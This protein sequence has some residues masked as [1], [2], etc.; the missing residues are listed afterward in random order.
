MRIPNVG[1][2][3]MNLA[4]VRLRRLQR[5]SRTVI[6]AVQRAGRKA[7]R[8]GE[9][10]PQVPALVRVRVQRGQAAIERVG[11]RAR[12]FDDHVLTPYR[13]ER[14][15]K[16]TLTRA[17]SGQHPIIV[18]PWTSEVGYEVLYWLPFL[19]WA[20][21]HYAVR[22]ERLVAVSRG[23]TAAWYE[24]IAR[25]YVEIFDLIEPAALAAHAA[26]RPAGGDQ[27]QMAP[28]EF[29]RHLT[30][31]V[32]QR[33]GVN[34]VAIWHPGLMYQLFRSF[35]YGDRS[36]QFLFRHMDFR[37]PRIAKAE[38]LSLPDQYV[39]VKFYTGPALPATDSNTALL[40]DLV[41]RVAA[42]T[43]VVL[44][45]TTWTTDEHRDYAFDGIP[46]V[47]TLRPSLDPRTNLDLQTRVIAGARQFIG[48][49][50]GLAWLAP[51]LGV[52]TLAVYEDDRYLTAHLY[53]ARYAYRK[54]NA[55]RFATVNIKAL[56]G[57]NAGLA[58][59][60]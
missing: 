39:A 35:W 45:D 56:R 44:L 41:E 22:P 25:R 42:S 9:A 27:K 20:V 18:G 21:D 54:S 26:T 12:R 17:A 57:V 59:A 28:S 50:G 36:R 31:L 49:C 52:D 1:R 34:R 2:A 13:A 60:F 4:G 43:P 30:E 19:R 15:V 53:A 46:G 48:T 38:G 33:L 37:Y 3:M 16:R 51:F 47:T 5:H 14:R 7:T 40:C 55:A 29:D 32:R 24:G 6:H 23:G 10:I 58:S 11:K 8:Y